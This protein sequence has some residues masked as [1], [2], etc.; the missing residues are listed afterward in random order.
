MRLRVDPGGPAQDRDDQDDD[1]LAELV[2]REPTPEFAAMMAEEFR[3]LLDRLGDEQLRQIALRTDG[4]L[5]RR[6]DRRTAGSARART[7][8]RR[9]EL[10]RQLWT[11]E[12]GA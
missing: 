10:I 12:S 2:G 8:A 7:V 9:L 1:R 3:R 5:H 11:E 6:R 4:R